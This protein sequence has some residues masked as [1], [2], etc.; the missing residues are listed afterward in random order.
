MKRHWTPQPKSW[1]RARLP[2]FT[3]AWCRPVAQSRRSCG[4][5]AGNWPVK[6]TSSSSRT[7]VPAK[8]WLKW[9][10]L[11]AKPLQNLPGVKSAKTICRSSRPNSNHSVYL[12]CRASAARFQPWPP[13]RPTRAAQQELA[14]KSSAIWV[15]RPMTSSGCSISTSWTN[16]RSF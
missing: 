5:V 13:S 16:P 10:S 3:S 14:P 11:F 15:Y 2:C 8:R 12:A 4:T 1:G 9:R 7:P 6:C